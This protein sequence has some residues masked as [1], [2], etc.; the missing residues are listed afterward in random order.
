[1]P[2]AT[3]AHAALEHQVNAYLARLVAGCTLHLDRAY[4]PGHWW[5]DSSQAHQVTLGIEGHVLR[6]L[7]PVDD[8]VTPRGGVWLRRPDPCG[9]ILRGRVSVPLHA[10]LSGEVEQVNPRYLAG[11]KAPGTFAD[12]DEWL[13]R[14]TPHENPE[15]VP[16]LYRGAEALAW[17]LKNI[18]LL[19]RSLREALEQQAADSVGA[20]LADGGEPTLNLEAVLG[21]ARF[22]AVVD[23][24]FRI[25]SS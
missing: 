25:H 12:G 22:E 16:G 1:M 2:V 18:Q 4:S 19:Q 20:T 21:R 5:V 8:I 9:W 23:R 3:V 17:H 24:M 11:V 15:T 10:P 6:A 7:Q 13:L 14:V